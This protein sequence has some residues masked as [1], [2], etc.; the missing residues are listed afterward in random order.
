MLESWEGAPP[1]IVCG[2]TSAV[3]GDGAGSDSDYGLATGGSAWDVLER[4]ERLASRLGLGAVAVA[5][6]VHGSRVASIRAGSAPGDGVHVQGEADGLATDAS[7][8]LLLVTVADCVPVFLTAAGGRVLALAHAGWRGIAAGVLEASIDCL[9]D[10]FG[11]SRADIRVHLGPAICGSCYEVGPEVA[12]A[13]GITDG[14]TGRVDLRDVLASR[15]MATGIGPDRVSRSQICTRCAGPA[16]FSHRRS[17][18]GA[19]RMAAYIGRI[20]G[21]G[22]PDGSPEGRAGELR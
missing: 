13:L 15:A 4:Y 12:V 21:T 8:V 2:V 10:D 16:A 3:P 11:A 5:R 14:F 7:D 20:A 18:T 1:H 17:G 6:Q 22:P 9:T 19:G